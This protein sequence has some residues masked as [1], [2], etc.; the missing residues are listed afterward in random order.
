MTTIKVYPSNLP[1]EPIE[2][3]NVDQD[4]TLGEWLSSNCPS[5]HPGPDQ[6][7]IAIVSRGT[8]DNVIVPHE[9]IDPLDWDSFRLAGKT[10]ELRPVPQ[11][12]VTGLII[13]ALI[14]G[15]V[16]TAIF[17]KPKIPSMS[18]AQGIQGQQLTSADINANQPRLN[19]I[20]PEIAGRYRVYPDYLSQPRKYFTDDRR[21]Q[22]IDAV[23]CI[24]QGEYQINLD[25]VFIEN[26]PLNALTDISDFAIWNPG[27][28]LAGTNYA[29][30]WHN[31]KEVGSSTGSTGLRLVAGTPGTNKATATAYRVESNTISVPSGGGGGVLPQDWEIGNVLSVTISNLTL[32]VVDG[33][34]TWTNPVIDKVRGQFSGLNLAVGDFVVMGPVNRGGYRVKSITTPINDPGTASTIV[35]NA[36][37]LLTFAL[38][39]C[40]FEL[41]GFVIILDQ[42]YSLIDY[43]IDDIESKV[44]GVTITESGGI[45]TITEESPFSGENISLSGYYA[46]VLGS[47]PVLT[48]GTKT[49][50]YDEMTLEVWESYTDEY[51][52]IQYRWANASQLTPGTFTNQYLEKAKF[53]ISPPE[54]PFYENVY[55]F[56]PLEYRITDL[57]TGSIPG[58]TGTIGFELQRLNADRTSD[59]SWTGFGFDQVLNNQYV[60][61]KLVQDQVVGGWLGPF[62]A[63][64]ANESTAQIQYD[65]FFPAGLAF[66]DDN[67]NIQWRE[68]W[69]E[70]QWRQNG[71]AWSSSIYHSVAAATKDQL[72]WTLTLDLPQE[73]NNVD[74]RMRRI[75]AENTSLNYLEKIEWYGLRC[76][77]ADVN[78]Y[79]GVTIMT[80]TLRGSDKISTNSEN[81]INLIATRKLNGV[82]TR[83]IAE[84][85]KYVCSTVGYS[86]S[87]LNQTEFNTLAAIWNAR[88]D[89]YDMGIVSQTTV[90]NELSRALNAGFAEFT[91]DHGQIRPVR[92]QA[93]TTFEQM[94]TPQNMLEPLKRQF[95]AYD[96]DEYNGV[97]VE[98][99]DGTTW[100]KET[101][102]CRLSG[103]AG[104]RVE[105]IRLD[106][107][108][109]RTR[110]WRIGM[111]ERRMQ[112]YRRKTYQFKTELD[113]L[114]SKYL[115]YCLLAD[116]VPGYDQSA[117]LVDYS[118]TGG[119]AT[120]TIS[121]PRSGNLVALRRPDGSLAGPYAATAI[122]DH[123][124]TIPTPD[125]SPIIPG[126]SQ[127][128]THVL[129]G[130]STNYHYD[131]LITEINPQGNS[132]S[133]QAV[134]Y[135][136]RVYADDDNS[137]A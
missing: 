107:V 7:I 119:V 124:F 136:A 47:A 31:S 94:Y 54:P 135:D 95:Q 68:V 10:I 128:P 39:P 58:G 64:P 20:I 48:K 29:H 99:V 125:F 24:G 70:V 110:A 87:D 113:A 109:D 43:L 65:V 62:R 79:P 85:A 6:P 116:D 121:E 112:K 23:F 117:L 26:T 36:T 21:S 120:L 74:L 3:H 101:V 108:T 42:D 77:L 44:A 92:D 106:G 82:A 63:T 59:T 33:G 15:A 76:R 53:E 105:K 97:D 60:S 5:Y 56:S 86:S 75:S 51:G 137:P 104:T 100:E 118:A 45:L 93:R 67:G 30:I 98:Y 19:G 28:S 41:N 102:E 122:S 132:V 69:F 78:S 81:K 25:E 52:E 115:S 57:I 2:C 111:R 96:P 35:G 66:I 130:H 27:A 134:N 40:S 131:V 38:T 50:I 129:I 133:V 11:D 89:Y 71:G 8:D 73:Y 1:G 127:E 84:W 80:L 12:L 4:I 13:G 18:T 83:S 114:N 14:L 103:D 61:I 32:E 91:I 46:P 22:L 90:K 72:G 123:V 55:T 17:L 49:Q 16:A 37:A 126:T 9:T 88:G 34:G